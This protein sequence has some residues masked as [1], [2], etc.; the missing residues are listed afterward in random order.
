MGL[1][2]DPKCDEGEE[3]ID[4]KCEPI[5]C[6]EGEELIDGKCV[7]VDY[8]C[9]DEQTDAEG[10]ECPPIECPEVMPYP[11]DDELPIEPE[12]EPIEC[13]EAGYMRQGNECV[14]VDCEQYEGNPC[15]D[16]IQPGNPNAAEEII[17]VD[18]E[19]PTEGIDCELQPELCEE[20][21]VEIPE[22]EELTEEIETEEIETEDI[23][24]EE[25]VEEESG[26]NEGSE[27]SGGS[28]GEASE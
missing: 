17:P 15:N 21:I 11:C 1:Y 9:L 6:D 12:P 26:D 8:G 22:E 25:E 19:V 7:P 27:E 4:G 24:E 5:E 13:S 18:E 14:A 16:L 10:Y 23:E 28:E 20:N 3:L 2:P